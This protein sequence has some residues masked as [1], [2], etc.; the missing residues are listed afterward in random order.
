G[1]EA[2]LFRHE[3]ATVYVDQW[4]ESNILDPNNSGGTGNNLFLLADPD[5]G[6]ARPAVV[7]IWLAG[8]HYDATK[9]HFVA[10]QDFKLDFNMASPTT[11]T[12]SHRFLYG[13]V[14]DTVE[15]DKNEIAVV[16]GL[17]PQKVTTTPKR[18]TGKRFSHGSHSSLVAKKVVP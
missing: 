2:L 5:T 14:F 6:A 13:R 10:P 16:C 9:V 3:A 18:S 12:N 11:M 8:S 7:P 4:A 17:P 15:A 1:P